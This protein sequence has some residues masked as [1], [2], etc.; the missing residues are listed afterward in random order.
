[1]EE[2][3]GAD[4]GGHTPSSEMK[5]SG[6]FMRP[7]GKKKKKKKAP[8]PDVTVTPDGELTKSWLTGP[9]TKLFS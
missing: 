5:N 4:D 3:E 1:M 6:W 2:S 9:L 7:R 8:I